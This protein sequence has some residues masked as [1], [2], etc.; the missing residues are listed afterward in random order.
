M[1]RRLASRIGNADR[2]TAGGAPSGRRDCRWSRV[3]V[4]F[5][6]GMP[7]VTYNPGGATY[8]SDSATI[9]LHAYDGTRQ[10]VP[11]T[12]KWSALTRDGLSP[13][14][15]QQTLHFLD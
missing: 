7:G 5:L 2:E 15:G 9:V 1:G 11:D 6:I 4:D 14:A 3:T 13:N 12:F 10:L 8:M